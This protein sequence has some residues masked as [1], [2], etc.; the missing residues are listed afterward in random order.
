MNISW[1]ILY[2]A[3]FIQAL[4][5]SLIL[6]PLASKLGFRWQLIDLPQENKIH[7]VPKARSGGLAIFASFVL[8]ICGDLVLLRLILEHTTFF[9]ADVLRFFSNIPGI[10]PKL[11]IANEF[12]N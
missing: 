11:A 3:V 7:R 2:V 6:T 9:S 4:V 1:G 12:I 5:L 10:L 8:V